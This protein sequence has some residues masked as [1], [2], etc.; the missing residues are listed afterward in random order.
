MLHFFWEGACAP[1]WHEPLRRLYDTELVYVSAG[2]CVVEM[3][4]REYVL[5]TGDLLLIPPA[6]WQESRNDSDVAV[7]RHCLHFDWTPE[8]SGL[9]SPLYAFAGDPWDA[10]LVHQVPAG[11]VELLPWFVPE[12]QTRELREVVDLMFRR[13]RLSQPLGS[14]LL[15]AVLQALLDRAGGPGGG[16]AEPALS[17]S[18]RAVSELKHYLETHYAEPLCYDDYCAR[19]GLSSGHLCQAFRRLVGRPPHTYLID[20]RLQHARRLLRHS[21]LTIAEVA[22]AVGIDNPNYFSRLFRQRFG[23]TPRQFSG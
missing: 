12:A 21:Q 18:Q 20:V 9:Q 3:L 15:T 8:D 2:A 6:T 10:D 7:N 5:R 17:R 13:L 4:E 11:V 22:R 19:T 1:G 16:P 14:H 23:Q